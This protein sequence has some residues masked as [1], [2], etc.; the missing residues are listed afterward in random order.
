MLA[1]CWEV[2]NREN[3]GGS[4]TN[5][6]I[7]MRRYGITDIPW[8]K[9]YFIKWKPQRSD[10]FKLDNSQY[11]Q[12]PTQV[13]IRRPTFLTDED[14]SSLYCTKISTVLHAWTRTWVQTRLRASVGNCLQFSWSVIRP[15][16]RAMIDP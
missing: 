14:E 5:S 12:R 3:P 4:S 16:F 10:T 11:W 7:F 9:Q 2:L 13:P 8:T 1:L 6:L 15:F